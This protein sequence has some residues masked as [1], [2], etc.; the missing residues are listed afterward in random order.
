[1]PLT[2]C[3]DCNQALLTGDADDLLQT[4]RDEAYEADCD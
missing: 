4:L 1:V 2:I 3:P